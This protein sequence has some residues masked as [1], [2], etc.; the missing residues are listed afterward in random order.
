MKTKTITSP[1]EEFP[2]TVKLPARLTMPQA[3]AYERTVQQLQSLEDATPAEYDNIMLDLLFECVEEWGLDDYEDITPETFPGSP[4]IPSSKLIAHL[5][6][7]L[8]DIYNPDA[9]NA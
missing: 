1:V 4:R 3:L 5:F 8:A 9:P 2:G 7:E 6:E